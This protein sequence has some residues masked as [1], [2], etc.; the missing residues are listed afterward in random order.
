MFLPRTL[1]SPLENFHFF[2]RKLRELELIGLTTAMID[3]PIYDRLFAE[4]FLFVVLHILF[5]QRKHIDYKQLKA[6]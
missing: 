6:I 2:R 3:L 1:I 5:F 4:A